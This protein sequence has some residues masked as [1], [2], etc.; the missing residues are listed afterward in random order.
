MSAHLTLM[1][2]S[3]GAEYSH[4]LLGPVEVSDGLWKALA[5]IQTHYGQDVPLTFN[6][7]LSDELPHDIPCTHYGNT[8]LGEYGDRLKHVSVSELMPIA[9]TQEVT[10]S[11]LADACWAY[12]SALPSTWRVAP[13]WH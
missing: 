11:W 6:T 10:E 8:Q 5:D 7:Y 13:Y 4:T 2:F 1:P 12:L 3:P 9:G